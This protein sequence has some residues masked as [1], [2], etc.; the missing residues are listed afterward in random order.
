MKNKKIGKADMFLSLI[1]MCREF[2]T[3]RNTPEQT[4][5]FL[6]FIAHELELLLGGYY[7]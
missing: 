2:D 4:S 6:N 5:A 3:K 7:E 1:R